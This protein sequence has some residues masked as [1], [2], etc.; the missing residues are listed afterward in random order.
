MKIAIIG[1][2]WYGCHMALELKKS[3]HDVEL[4][5]KNRSI[6]SGISGTFG[7]RLHRGPHYPRS[8]KT[9][10]ICST[11]FDSFIELYPELV[12]ELEHAYYALGMKDA[13]QNPPKVDA[14]HFESVCQEVDDCQTIIPD[15]T[16][17]NSIQSLYN[18]NEPSIA[19]GNRLRTFFEKKL[20]Q[21]NIKVNLNSPVKD[22]RDLGT[23]VEVIAKDSNML[24]DSAINATSFKDCTSNLQ[25]LQLPADLQIT[26]QVCLA[27]VYR[28]KQSNGK[29]FSFI[30]MDGWYPCLM[31][32]VKD[33]EFDNTYILTHGCYTIM[34]SCQTP[35]HAKAILD[36]YTDDFI[37]EGPRNSSEQDMLRYCPDFLDRFEYLGWKGEVLAKPRT[38]SEFRSAITFGYGNIVHV[39]PG[40]VSNV[41]NAA[42]ESRQIIENRNCKKSGNVTYASH[43]ILDIAQKDI[44][45]HPVSSDASTV[46]L[47][48]YSSKENKY[49]PTLFGSRKSTP[50]SD[51]LSQ[52]RRPKI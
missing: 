31:P 32:T 42:N 40:K 37:N 13:H 17:Y 15:Q 52:E 4:F 41:I 25:D 20:E 18:L 33:D 6:M 23:G 22:M 7:I 46:N 51:S 50:P 1:A 21:A 8:K 30:V 34:A 49:N 39:I 16:S 5:E 14:N 45:D 12:V 29:P 27:L 48:I 10:E 3:G 19:L 26:F 24:F 43:G 44:E 9:R 36:D 11:N 38:K 28:D 2:G 47:N 35:E